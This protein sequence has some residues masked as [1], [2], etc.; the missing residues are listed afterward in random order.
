MS[1]DEFALER[2]R[3]NPDL[4]FDALRKAAES[5]G[6]PLLPIHYG[7][8]R[9]QLG[10]IA[11]TNQR[12]E[13][14]SAEAG[15]AA[16]ATEQQAEAPTA[17]PTPGPG[18]SRPSTPAFEFLVEEL[19]REPTISY[20]ELKTTADARGLKIA[21]IMYGRAKALLGLVPVRPRGQGK[22]RKKQGVA[23]LTRAESASAEQFAQQ[24]E[25]VRDI[26][27][28]R[29]IARQLDQERRQLRETLERLAHLIDE[30]LN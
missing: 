2:L 20:G 10:L 26:E 1:A 18:L 9:R 23:G 15:A 8:A 21:P 3:Q 22:N 27:G 25:A 17:T 19:R 13:D 4:G 12:T 14:A 6:L 5:E 11:S 29:A 7:R 30:S 24:L 16:E 28:V